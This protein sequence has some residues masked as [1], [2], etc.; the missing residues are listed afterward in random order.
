M[1][2]SYVLNCSVQWLQSTVTMADIILYH[3][4]FECR[5]LFCILM[6]VGLI[7][8]LNLLT[9]HQND[10]HIS[11]PGA[12]VTIQAPRATFCRI[13]WMQ[14]L[15]C[16][17]WSLER[18]K[19]CWGSWFKLLISTASW[20]WKLV[21]HRHGKSRGKSQECG[22]DETGRSLESQQPE[23]LLRRQ[24]RRNSCR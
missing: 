8:S 9:P 3:S 19:G 24:D 5:V 15:A 11:S 14:L 22:Q 7:N 1:D 4:K 13:G 21:K 16:G 10:A 20:A 6:L 18:R 12:F 17:F 2:P 23:G